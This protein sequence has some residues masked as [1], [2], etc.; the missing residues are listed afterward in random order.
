MYLFFKV[1][2]HSI[3]LDVFVLV[4]EGL[5]LLIIFFRRPPFHLVALDVEQPAGKLGIQIQ[6]II[7]NLF[8]IRQVMGHKYRALLEM[9]VI[10]Q[11]PGLDHVRY[12]VH[13]ACV[14]RPARHDGNVAD[15]DAL[16]ELLGQMQERSLLFAVASQLMQLVIQL[17]G[18]DLPD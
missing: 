4:N 3:G 18:L 12:H 17:V 14:V 16:A 7:R 15:Q 13:E 11:Y 1:I 9:Y 2:G 8:A 6:D 10:M 5:F